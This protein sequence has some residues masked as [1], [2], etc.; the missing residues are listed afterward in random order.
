L[1]D[2]SKI[3]QIEIQVSDIERAKKFYEHA[4]G[5][6]ESPAELFNYTILEVPENCGFGISLVP[7]VKGE[8][9]RT[10]IYFMVEK[11]EEIVKKVQEF[12]GSLRFGPKKL[13]PHGEIYQV[14]DPDGNPFGL[15]AGT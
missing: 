9:S 6:K 3:C 7:A 15:V 1:I 2:P 8:G 10:V 11:P 13:P 12:G 5:W 14:C 4:F